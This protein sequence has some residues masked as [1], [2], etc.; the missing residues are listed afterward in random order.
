[1]HT[2]ALYYQKQFTKD[3]CNKF[4]GAVL[5]TTKMRQGG[6]MAKNKPNL[7]IRRSMV[8]TPCPIKHAWFMDRAR[9]IVRMGN[10]QAWCFDMS[11]KEEWQFAEYEAGPSAEE[12]DFYE[13]HMDVN[14]KDGLATCRKVSLGVQLSDPA[15]YDGGDF[16]VHHSATVPPPT[17]RDLG[18]A[19]VFPSFLIHNITPITRGK[20]YS[21]VAWF[22][23]RNFI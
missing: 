14:M 1:M 23:G 13:R 8:G 11:G 7:S 15:E 20:R 5:A 10:D 4:I 22:Y 9:R 17:F 6:I 16:H 2:D 21:L 12:N 3:E 19:V 18:A